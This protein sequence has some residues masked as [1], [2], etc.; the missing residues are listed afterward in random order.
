MKP[1]RG[2]RLK[3]SLLGV[4]VVA[5]I[6]WST[7]YLGVLSANVTATWSYD[8]GPMPVCSS[9]LSTG[10]ID[11][12]EV[13]DITNQRQIKK[14]YSAENPKQVA[15]KVDSISV[16]FKYGPPFGQR[17]IGVIAVG[18]DLKGNRITSNPYAARAV[19]TIRPGARMA[20][21]F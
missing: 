14:I 9:S 12:F 5:L 16:S 13:E 20:L 11:H 7:L 15:G 21:S 18:R 4:A 17:T 8:F 19:V 6:S 10:C 1:S 2:S 3:T